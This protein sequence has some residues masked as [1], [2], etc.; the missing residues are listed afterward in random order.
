MEAGAER[1]HVHLSPDEVRAI[2]DTWHAD[3]EKVRYLESL[4]VRIARGGGDGPAMLTLPPMSY[5]QRK[6]LAAVLLR[7]FDQ[8]DDEPPA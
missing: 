3:R 2:A 5:L 4:L 6:N 7:G 1:D 8:P